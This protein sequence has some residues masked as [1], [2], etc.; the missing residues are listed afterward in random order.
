M[1][2]C[3]FNPVIAQIIGVIESEPPEPLA[4]FMQFDDILNAPVADPTDVDDW[5]TFYGA[6]FTSVVVTGN[7]VELFGGVD[8]VIAP[9]LFQDNVNLLQIIDYAECV[10]E[11]QQ[12]AFNNLGSG[13]MTLNTAIFN[14][15]VTVGNQAFISLQTLTTVQ[16]NALET[17]GES[18]FNGVAMSVENSFDS[19]V[20]IGDFGFAGSGISISDFDGVTTVG[21]SAFTGCMALTD[22]SF[23]S[24]TSAGISSFESCG[25]TS[26]TFDVL[27]TIPDNMFTGA[28]SLATCTFLLAETAGDSAFNNSGLIAIT[29]AMFPVLETTGFAT[30]GDLTQC[31]SIEISSLITCGDE[32][33]SGEATNTSILESLLLPSLVTAGTDNFA[34]HPLLET[35][36]LSS[37]TSLLDLRFCPSLVSVDIAAETLIGALTGSTGANMTFVNMPSITDESGANFF[38]TTVG[39]IVTVN[40]N[41]I[42]E[43]IDGGN[44]APWIVTLL[45]D[46]PG[47]TVNYI[48]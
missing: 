46:N 42:L 20:T 14:A 40:V 38:Q 4:L 13:A 29:D 2:G 36:D 41:V 9:S 45:A 22:V 11:I 37:L 21:A 43:T 28:S 19:L 18:A 34:F 7:D 47:S 25:A 5:N 6:T 8:V 15:C 10:I 26:A 33:F 39:N 1:N 31:V 17:V 23:A 16:F 35:V 24:C 12:D 30:F 44:P 32:D 48:P 27:V 3:C